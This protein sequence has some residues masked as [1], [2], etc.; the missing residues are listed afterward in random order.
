[1]QNN[2]NDNV[3]RTEKIMNLRRQI[4]F[5]ETENLHKKVPQSD[6]EMVEK[7]IKQ[8]KRFVDNEEVE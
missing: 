7:I 1:M 6:P 8:I 2:K 3:N 5:L 4:Y